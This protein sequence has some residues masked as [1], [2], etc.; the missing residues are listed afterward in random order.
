VKLQELKG[1]GP[2]I[3]EK[4]NKLGIYQVEDLLFHIPSKYLDKTTISPIL[5][6]KENQSALVQG[7]IIKVS[8]FFYKKK[9]ATIKIADES[10]SLRI[11]YFNISKD[12]VSSFKEG[13]IVRVFGEM[14]KVGN[15]KEMIHP[16]YKFIDD[17][18][19]SLEETYTP[20]YQ[21][22]DGINQSRIRSLIKQA[23]YFLKENKLEVKKI[24]PRKIEE[25]FKLLDIKEC[26]LNIHQ[27]KKIKDFKKFEEYVY[28]YK[29]RFIFE[30]LLSHQLNFERV[31]RFNKTIKAFQINASA[32]NSLL[33][34]NQLNFTLTNSQ[35]EVISE[36]QNDLNKENPMLRL[37]QGDVGSGK[38]IV[39]LFAALHVILN[40]YQ[41]AF[42]APTEILAV[43]HFHYIKN[44]LESFNIKV[45]LLLGNQK[46][47][48]K[49]SIREDIK[50]G[51]INIVVGTH[52]LIQKEILFKNLALTIIDE[53]HKFGVHQ[54]MHLFSKGKSNEIYPHQLILTATPIPRTLAMTMYGHLDYS[55]IDEMPLGRKKIITVAKPEE[56]RNE[57]VLKIK[58]ICENEKIQVYWVCP[59]IEESE[60][61]QCRTAT[62]TFENLQK[63]LINMKVGL[64]HGR[65]S[66]SEKEIIMKDFKNNKIDILVATTIIEVGLDIKNANIIVIENAERM[67]LSQLHQL[68]GRVGRGSKQSTCILIYK[69]GLSENALKRIDVLRNSSDGFDIAAEDLK[70]RGPGELLGKKQKGSINY[71]IANI[72]NDYILLPEV[73]KCCNLLTEKEID[74]LSRRWQ[75]E[76]VDISRA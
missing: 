46:N 6:L 32:Q 21:V 55:I 22:T 59:L 7:E 11:R 68:R 9:I 16:E 5:D 10:S 56:K 1:V 67:G 72:V 42:M 48:E 17:T 29:K 61:L 64:I 25:K 44:L 60:T 20:V 27:P 70:L 53:Q 23:I 63:E 28:K 57:V 12:Q 49:I 36:I 14:R 74:L 76:E 43:Q 73:K 50:L 51:N 52:S 33:L 31:K 3:Q 34:K 58:S 75:K 39:A 26:L 4:L 13:R 24:I 41:V 38:T 69:T 30:E 8:S 2:K 54:R 47:S 71:R 15:T 62:E 18:N 66:F 45:S 35:Q 19:N 65:M 37:V 40:G